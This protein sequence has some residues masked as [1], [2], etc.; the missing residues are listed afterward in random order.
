M[1]HILQTLINFSYKAME[2]YFKQKAF[3]DLFIELVSNIFF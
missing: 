1:K 3:F 2:V